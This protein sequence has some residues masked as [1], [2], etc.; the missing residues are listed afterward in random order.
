MLSV[1]FVLIESIKGSIKRI[2]IILKVNKN[3][4]IDKQIL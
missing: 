2:K 3:D 4:I 1:V